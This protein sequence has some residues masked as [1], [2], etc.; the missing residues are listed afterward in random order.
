[1]TGQIANRTGQ[2]VNMVCQITN[3]VH[4]LA[5]L[6]DQIGNVTR[7]HAIGEV[8]AN[9]RSPRTGRSSIRASTSRS[10]CAPPPLTHAPRVPLAVEEDVAFNPSHISLRR[11]QTVVPD[12]DQLP[13]L[14]QESGR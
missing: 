7:P 10:R 13:N 6:T 14:L 12:P 9:I 3:L 5:K 2:L 8:I 4:Q 1:M 11:Y